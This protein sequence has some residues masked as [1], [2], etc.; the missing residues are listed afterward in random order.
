M[1]FSIIIPSHDGEETLPVCLEALALADPPTG[2]IEIILVDNA[3]KDQ[4]SAIFR[5]FAAATGAIVLHE[6]RRGKSHAL[7]LAIERASGAIL[8]FL[9][10]DIVVEHD[11]LAAYADAE[12]RFPDAAIFA[13]QI[14]PR[15]LCEPPTW[16]AS[17]AEEG[18]CCGCTPASLG[19]CWVDPLLAKGGNMAVRR[20]A[21]GDARFDTQNVNFGAQTVPVG[22]EDT[23]LVRQ[24]AGSGSVRYVSEARAGHLVSFRDQRWAAVFVR[25]LRIG[26]GNAAQGL[27][28]PARLPIAIRACSS[29][30]V[31]AAAFAVGARTTAAR[32][33]TRLAMQVGALDFLLRIKSRS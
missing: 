27:V 15:W 21:L 32:W 33:G 5:K 9:D 3:S 30:V 12:R 16:L 1:A 2:G 26:R 10:D 18:R 14:R 23:H 13:G 22:G 17:L 8:L 19:S 4:T 6:P 20:N 31:A 24:V 7:N 11:L 29:I 28:G 25:Y